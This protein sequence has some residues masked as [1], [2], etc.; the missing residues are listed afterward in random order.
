[1]E[2]KH[3]N[4]IFTIPNFLSLFRIFLIPAMVYLYIVKQQYVL[5]TALYAVSGITDI[6]DGFIA[7]KSETV[8]DVGKV[9]DP[10]ADK[11]TQ[12]A[13]M[14]CLLHRYPLMWLLLIGFILW[15][16]IMS[17]LGLI[18]IRR[19][20]T[21]ISSQWYGKAA[22]V[23]MFLCVALLILFPEM[24]IILANILILVCLLAVINACI[25]YGYYYIY[26]IS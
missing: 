11:L 20:G 16:V 9:L 18:A 7:R 10:V 8:T 17:V 23:T 24:P 2:N 19:A 1:M 25:L 21:V 6:L 3:K 22:T 13:L 4:Q 12:G 14:I 15:E 5:V 26:I